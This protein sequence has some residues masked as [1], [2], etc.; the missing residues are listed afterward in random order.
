MRIAVATRF[1]HTVGGVETYLGAALPGLVSRGHDVRVWH[2]FGLTEGAELMVPPEIPVRSLDADT[3]SALSTISAWRPD[4]VFLN[5]LSEPAI[6][7]R[8][9]RIAPML[10]LLH[11]YHG[12]CISGSKAF[13]FPSPQ[14]CTRALGPGCLVNYL[15]RRCGGW[16]P[17]TMVSGYVE[18]RRRQTLLTRCDGVATLSEHMRQ[19][20]IAQGVAPARA[21]SPPF[22]VP[23]TGGAVRKRRR[24]A[25]TQHRAT[26]IPVVT[27]AD[28]APLHRTD[29]TTEGRPCVSRCTGSARRDSARAVD[30][31]PSQAMAASVRNGSDRR[32][33][34][35][36]VNVR[37][38]SPAG[39]MLQDDRHSSRTP[40]CWW[41][42]VSGPS[43]TD[44]SAPKPRQHLF[45]PS[46]SMLAAS[47]SGSSTQKRAGLHNLRADAAGS[48]A[49]ALEDC[50]ADRERLSRWGRQAYAA[51]QT[52]SLGAHI[53]ALEHALSDVAGAHAP[54]Y[55]VSPEHEASAARA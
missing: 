28:A 55:T 27:A 9:G 50:L 32:R 31:S 24:T 51:S 38:D 16:S 10:V 26:T 19:E 7:E 48:L 2:E 30:P 49:R 29:G 40:I 15:P 4:V 39:S 3:D 14:V 1:A 33:E 34:C 21:V 17:L 52:R 46:P 20:C 47:A 23:Q 22:A 54:A 6:E 12:T 13:S 42:R 35:L 8:L 45:Q 18:Q 25:D 5:G 37:S 36:A 43:P 41:C 11:A 53:D 44:S